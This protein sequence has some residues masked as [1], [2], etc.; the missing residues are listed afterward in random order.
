MGACTTVAQVFVY[1]K[2]EVVIF[3][4]SFMVSL[5]YIKLLEIAFGKRIKWL[6][7]DGNST[8]QMETAAND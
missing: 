3:Q 5:K 2:L 7:A 8:V 1:Q 4:L 6:L